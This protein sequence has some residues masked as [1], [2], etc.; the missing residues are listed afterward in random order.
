MSPTCIWFNT[1]DSVHASSLSLRPD[2]FG[3]CLHVQNLGLGFNSDARPM[4]KARLVSKPHELLGRL[5]LRHGENVS[6]VDP[7]V[8]TDVPL[9]EIRALRVVAAWLEQMD[10]E[11]R[12]LKSPAR[13]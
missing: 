1:A 12:G 11:F 5:E 8:Y 4:V 7:F 6:D 13:C 10:A 9:S 2:E 3:V